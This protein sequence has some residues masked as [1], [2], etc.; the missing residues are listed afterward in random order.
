MVG[1]L[2]ISKKRFQNS[3]KNFGANLS[4]RVSRSRFIIYREPSLT[5]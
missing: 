2:E 3:W 5:T 4:L 1:M